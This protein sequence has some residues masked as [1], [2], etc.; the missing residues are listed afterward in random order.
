MCSLVEAMTPE[1]LLELGAKEVWMVFIKPIL[2]HFGRIFIHKLFTILLLSRHILLI[3]PVSLK[4]MLSR[5]ALHFIKLLCINSN[6][7][8]I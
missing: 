5:M 8:T 6:N 2:S 7:C 1:Q 4:A 3:I